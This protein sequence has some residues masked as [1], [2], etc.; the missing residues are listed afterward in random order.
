MPGNDAIDKGFISKAYEQQHNSVTKSN[1]RTG[2]RAGDRNR[3]LFK[4][5]TQTANTDMKRR[6]ITANSQ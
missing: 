3:L 6:A 2:K 5:H 1:Q 4:E